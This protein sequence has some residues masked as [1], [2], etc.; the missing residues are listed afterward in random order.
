MQ[1][2]FLSIFLLT[3]RV[4]GDRGS[5][6]GRVA[7]S[8]NITLGRMRWRVRLT[9]LQDN[10][11][12]RVAQLPCAFA[13]AKMSLLSIPGI[14]ADGLSADTNHA[15]SVLRLAMLAA[16]SSV[17]LLSGEVTG[18]AAAPSATASVTVLAALEAAAED[19]AAKGATGAREAPL[20]AA[21]VTLSP[22]VS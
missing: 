7:C 17:S 6:A 12:L 10:H 19:V 16:R 5:T 3:A 8:R 4:C 21:A 22:A 11:H 9:H 1:G 13:Q 14:L 20:V 15:C 18:H 2:L